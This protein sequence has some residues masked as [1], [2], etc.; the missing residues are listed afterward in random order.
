[1]FSKHVTS[2]SSAYFHDE[3]NRHENQRAAE[4]LL[5]CTTC[6]A[7]FEDVKLGARFAEQLQIKSAPD[8]VWAGLVAQL[9]QKG[10][11]FDP[12]NVRSARLWF[13]KPLAIAATI[14]VLVA[15]GLLM[16][17]SNR[18]TGV[19]QWNVARLGGS[20]RIDSQNI[21]DRSKLGVGQWLETDATSRA[22][23]DVAT[24]GNVEIDT[25][26]RVRLLETNSSEHRIEL[27]R[28]RLSAHISAPPRLFFVN[29]PSGVAED[30]GCAY[31]LDVDN[32]GNSVLHVTL[33]W[34]SLQLTDRESSV[35]AGAACA[36]RRGVGPGTPYFE[37]ASE[38][39]RTA[40]SRFDFGDNQSDKASALA[41]VLNE[42]R[43]RDAM[44]L[45]YLLMRVSS[46]DR[47]SVYDRMTSLVTPPQDVTREGVLNLDPKMLDR[48]RA[49]LSIRSETIRPKH[50][51]WK[52]LWSETL[53]RIHGL[54]GKR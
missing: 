37:D 51:F 5:S 7:D 13:M 46:V 43:P 14:I 8:S 33:G 38:L 21:G 23:I 3:L 52:K 41:A 19:G 16:L 4:H 28:G 12:K 11:Q 34:V 20:P 48:W 27:A 47:A 24:I 53:G 35:P 18:N 31:T 22:Q 9:D 39:F 44:T 54:E 17:R 42:A 25:N 30:L 32:D 1:M 2:L 36:M 29:T 49:Q 50:S 26:S 6:R 40:L 10:A 15:G 45:W